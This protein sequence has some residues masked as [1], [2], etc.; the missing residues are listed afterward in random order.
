MHMH[1]HTWLFVLH[2]PA[3]EQQEHAAAEQEH[4]RHRNPSNEAWVEPGGDETDTARRGVESGQ[5]EKRPTAVHA[6]IVLS[7]HHDPVDAICLEVQQGVTPHGD[8]AD[9]ECDRDVVAHHVDGAS[10]PVDGVFCGVLCHPGD[11]EGVVTDD[12]V[13]SWGEWGSCE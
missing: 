5:R 2:P 7:A 10:E 12:G 6:D 8:V 3:P 1:A 4:H 9:A 11:D 13:D